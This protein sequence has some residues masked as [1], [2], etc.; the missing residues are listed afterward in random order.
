MED[1]VTVAEG[2]DDEAEVGARKGDGER[3]MA[4]AVEAKL[5]AG[6]VRTVPPAPP[7][8]VVPAVEDGSPPALPAVV[9]VPA[10]ATVGPVPPVP[11]DEAGVVV[12]DGRRTAGVACFEI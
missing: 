8:V 5:A 2:A 1:V 3:V 7:P 6:P 10:A 4:A 11:R 12:S 9:S